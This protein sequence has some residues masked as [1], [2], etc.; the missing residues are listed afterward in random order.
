MAL[1]KSG[2]NIRLELE[3]TQLIEAY[4]HMAQIFKDAGWFEFF[5]TFQGHDEQ[6][7]MIFPQNFN[8]F[9]VVIG[10]LLMMVTEHSIAK[11]CIFPLGG[12][13]WCKKETGNGVCEPVP[14]TRKT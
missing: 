5:T 1:N 12:E 10:K 7:S 4:P 2:Q 6:V 14:D 13:R 11:P 8:S 9:E 3:G